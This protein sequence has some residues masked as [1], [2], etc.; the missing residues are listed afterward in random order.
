VKAVSLD[1]ER[2]L[3]RLK[4]IVEEASRVFP[5]IVEVR[6][7]GSLAKGEET[8][9]SDADLFI[10]TKGGKENPVERMK[11]YFSFFS[12]R[13]DIGVDMIVEYPSQSLRHRDLLSSKG[14][15]PQLSSFL[16]C[17]CWLC[18]RKSL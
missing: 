13:M 1:R 2:V 11:P 17:S 18:E 10:V 12:D 8:G 4:E 14:C 5:E 15:R 9:L 7:F 16:C 3:R 6:L